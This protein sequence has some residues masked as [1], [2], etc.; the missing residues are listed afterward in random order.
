MKVHNT[1]KFRMYPKPEQEEVLFKTIGAARKMYNLLL[2]E[3]NANYSL[4]KSENITKEEYTQNKNS[5]KPIM[6]TRQEEYDYLSEVD[7][8]ALKYAYKHVNRA[9]SNFFADHSKRPVFKSRNHSKWTYT[10]CRAS[11]KSKNLRLA[12][13]GWLYLPR[14]PKSP[15]KV[16]VSQNPVGTLVSATIE[17]THSGKWFVSLSY[18]HHTQAPVY[19][20]TIGEITNPIGVDMG[21]KELAIT[22]DGEFFA[23]LRHAYKAKRKIAQ[24]D[25]SLSRKREQAKKDKRD[26]KDCKNYQKTKA[27]R[28]RAYEKVKNQREDTLH[29]I[30]TDLINN[31]DFIA[32]EDLSA[33]NLK[34]N[35]KLA[36]AISDVSWYSFFAKLK[37][38]A[39]KQ[40]KIIQVIDR[41]YAS[42]QIC[43]CCKS[44]TGPKGFAEL[45]V[46]S[47][48]CTQCGTTHDRD[49]NAARNILTQGLLEFSTTGTVG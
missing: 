30:T 10:T 42:T 12:K 7:S 27:K 19:P 49:I 34:K 18:E 33:E 45:N 11:K 23:N 48:T 26:L 38:K 31:H 32:V 14:M 24:L 21:L 44:I 5:I 15:V 9:F 40:G 25:R 16:V 20:E 8:T 17:K 1:Y 47:W 37:Y 35:H 28:A 13:N 29:K 22:S 3:Y 36:F 6:F 41:Y 39:E 43:S 2:E 4:Y 46:R